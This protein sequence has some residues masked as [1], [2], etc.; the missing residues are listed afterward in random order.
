MKKGLVVF[1]AVVITVLVVKQGL[2]YV[3]EHQEALTPA[4]EWAIRT[5]KKQPVEALFT[6]DQVE[7][8][9]FGEAPHGA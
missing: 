7:Q 6:T 5:R 4:E 8:E 9:L 1:V 2:K 3:V